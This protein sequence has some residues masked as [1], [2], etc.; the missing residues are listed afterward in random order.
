MTVQVLLSTIGEFAACPTCESLSRNIHSHYQRILQD[1]PM[2]SYGLQLLVTVRKFFC[3]NKA[4]AQRIFCERLPEVAR[5][6]GRRTER[7]RCI[8]QQISLSLGGAPSERLSHQLALPAGVDLLLDL[9]RETTVPERGPLYCVG[10]DDWAQRRG[11]HYGTIIINLETHEVVELLPDRT[12]DTL[13]AW[14]EKHPTIRIVSRDRASAYA[15]AIAT[16]LPAAAQVADRWHLLKN[17]TDTLYRILQSE[18]RY[19]KACHD[20]IT[21]AE[22]TPI[23]K[24]EL[25]QPIP[26][27]SDERR[28]KRVAAARELASQG[29]ASKEIARRLGFHPKTISRDLAGS[30]TVLSIRRVR[31][32]ILDPYKSYLQERVTTGCR[33]A[34]Q[35][36]RELQNL[37]FMG[38]ISIVRAFLNPRL[39]KKNNI[40]TIVDKPPTPR[41]VAHLIT[42]LPAKLTDHES[43]LLNQLSDKNGHLATAIRLGQ[44]FADM[45]RQKQPEKLNLWLLKAKQC[46]IVRLRNFAKGI[47]QDYRAVRAA[48]SLSY[49]NGPTEGHINRLKC[50]KRQMY[51]RAKIDLLRARLIA[52]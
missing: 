13:A 39:L 8:Q 6:W 16:A 20:E 23:P 49:S 33:N 10:V 30:T 21:R 31:P 47:C 15:Q 4:C 17:M 22:T 18:Y 40:S 51:G 26:T 34:A 41:A 37:G 11:S 5:A 12:V 9:A 50:I 27:K 38:G 2:T 28:Q 24:V 29:L 42:K 36:Y 52:G 25:V 35:L 43:E 46:G 45:I 48:F 1:L 32:S 3:R 19:L 14:L 44:G 7:L